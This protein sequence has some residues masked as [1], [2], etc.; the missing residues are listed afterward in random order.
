MHGPHRGL[1]RAGVIGC[2]LALAGVAL[3]PQADAAGP[4]TFSNTSDITINDA[5]AASPYPSTIDVTGLTTAITDVDVTLNGFSHSCPWDVAVLL[6]A[7][8]GEQSLL[9]ADVGTGQL[10]PDSTD[11][12]ITFDD[13]ASATVPY[14]PATGTYRPT[15][16][17]TGSGN[18]FPAPAPSGTAHPLALSVFNGI[19][20]NGTWSLYV[21]DENPGDSGDIADG[22]SLSITTAPVTTE[23]VTTDTT[24]PDTRITRLPTYPHPRHSRIKFTATESSVT[25]MCSIDRKP[26]LACIS[27]VDYRG[28]KKGKHSFS[29]YAVDAAGNADQTPATAKFRVGPRHRHPSRLG[30]NH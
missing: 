11:A 13:S 5:S 18:S 20:G 8:T 15:D 10:C 2:A 24:A 25:F 28:L 23:P 27:P 30:K 9:M 17:D 26:A 7:P 3:P 1:G 21:I 22:W 29:V 19:A 12:D 6:V 14:P 4:T 16:G